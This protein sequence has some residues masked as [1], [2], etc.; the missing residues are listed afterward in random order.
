M[1]PVMPAPLRILLTSE[2]DRTLSELREAQKLPQRIRDRAHML[3]LNALGWNVPEIAEIFECHQHTVRATLRRWE[4]RGLGGLGESPGR[5]AKPKWQ[6]EDLKYLT[7]SRSSD[8]RTYNSQQLAEKLLKER[9]VDL[10][11]DRI[12]RLLKKKIIAG[13]ERE[14]A[15]KES[16]TL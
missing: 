1:S 14:R 5:G 13:N 9:E 7:D 3:R 16:K 11:G 2:E 15:R 10:S 6:E 12:R 4:E 8:Q